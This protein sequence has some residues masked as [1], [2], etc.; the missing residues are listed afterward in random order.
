MK[1]TLHGKEYKINTD[2]RY[3]LLR[4]FKGKQKLTVEQTDEF[5]KSALEPAP[6]DEEIRQD[7]GMHDIW[8]LFAKFGKAANQDSIEMRK[9]FSQ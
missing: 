7:F 8:I 3:G 1:I 4:S 9:K 2:I 5:L 6:T